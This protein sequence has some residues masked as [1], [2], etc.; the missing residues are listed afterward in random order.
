MPIHRSIDD[1]QSRYDQAAS[2]YDK[3]HG[4][5]RRRRRFQIIDAPQLEAAMGCQ[6]V[7]ELGCGTGR[8]LTQVQA[9]KR[10]GIDVSF[11]MLQ[12][13]KQRHMQVAMGDAHRLP[14]PD[15]VFDAVI[16]GKGVFRY[17]DYE[18]AFAE[19]A[20]VLVDGGQL[21]VHQ[22]AARTWAVR[23]LLGTPP[24]EPMHISDLEQLRAPARAAGFDNERC[25]LWRSVRFPPYALTVP[26]W[27]PGK[28][29][30][31][32]TLVFRKI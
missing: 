32:C 17:L 1:V 5:L 3:S 9:A 13:A 14:F 20:R 18:K 23:D 6:R 28:L 15:G 26:E 7:L 31:H 2:R 22:Y 21:G 24:P 29:W 8:L 19:A 12:L 11:P 4:S 25:C 10:V 27:I 30:S 16:A